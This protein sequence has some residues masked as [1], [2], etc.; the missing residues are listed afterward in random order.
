MQMQLPQSSANVDVVVA[1][2][3]LT[4]SADHICELARQGLGK[5][6]DKC[7]EELSVSDARMET[8]LTDRGRVLRQLEAVNA[9]SDTETWNNYRLRQFRFNL[10]EAVAA[11]DKSGTDTGEVAS[12]ASY[13]GA[14]SK[15]AA[16]QPPPTLQPN[17]KNKAAAPC[18]TLGSKVK[19]QK[20]I[21]DQL[22]CPR[23]QSSDSGDEAWGTWQPAKKEQPKEDSDSAAASFGH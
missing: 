6:L 14:S 2:R 7:E 1:C 20:V 15:A 17:S 9:S 10:D 4:M 23:S 16:M 3:R 5:M 8:L 12:I 22:R 18:S 21:A 19:A 13:V 11:F